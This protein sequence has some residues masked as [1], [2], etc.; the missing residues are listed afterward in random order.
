MAVIDNET[1]HA[2]DSLRLLSIDMIRVAGSGHPGI[3]LGAAPIIYTLYKHHM[4]INPEEP[5]W[6]NRDRF[7]MSAGHGSA[8][9]YATLFMSGYDLTL[10]DL[11][12]FRQ[13]DS[14]C[15]GHPE[16]GKTPGV[17]CTTGMLGQGLATAV[18]IALSERYL[19][20]LVAS[21]VKKQKLINYYTYVLAGDGDLM[22]GV[23]NEA[24]AIAGNQGL[25]KLIVLYDSNDVTLDGE[26]K[27]SNTE[28]I[29][30]RYDA[31]G[32][33]IDYVKDGNDP[34]EIDRAIARAKKINGKPSLIEIKTVIG[35]GSFNE[36]K[37]VVHG[38]PL[39]KDDIDHIRQKME[40]TTG[41]LEIEEIALKNIR[42]EIQDRIKNNY[43][44]W[45][46]Y[47]NSF[48]S[49]DNPDI[50]KI[51][52]FLEFGEIGCDFDSKNFQIQPSYNEELRESNS[53]I[54][55]VISSKT[56]FFLGGSADLSSSCKTNLYKEAE[57]TRQYVLG[58]NIYFGVREHAMGSILNGMALNNFQVY[59]S[60]F[61]VLADYLKPAIRLSAMMNLPVTYIFTH[62]TIG[63][64]QDG[65]TH[66]PIEHLTMLRTI[67][68]LDVIRPA[69]INEVIGAWD[70][71]L[72]HRRPT[73]LIIS[74][75]TQHILAGTNSSLVSK[76]A[77][78]VNKEKERLDAI[79]IATGTDLTTACLIKDEFKN[80]HPYDIRIVSMPSIEIFRREPIE[81][82]KEIIPDGVK[83]IVIEAGDITPWL[84]YTKEEYIIGLTT[85]GDSGKPEDVL[86]KMNFN[87]EQIKERVENILK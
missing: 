56:K 81:Y 84:R 10:D 18:G 80:T 53:K 32:W 73:S 6:I 78:I 14:K 4:N 44:P 17:D 30:K 75:E 70:Y 68:N 74:K 35:R 3:C 21:K 7:I 40:I 31:L 62:D 69:D 46:E 50:I 77:Y 61:L 15:P 64:G 22:E 8:L 79:I 76:G 87:Y 63:I 45:L 51:V 82:Q 48:K 33:H 11:Q 5:D 60:T 72:E 71:I 57:L 28:D 38:K 12:K 29:L 43:N 65:A 86:T 2:I 52:R 39:T 36:G 47:F 23:T 59:G 49:S 1:K 9:L 42:R 19:E 55:N 41:T 27:L 34:K 67:P 37:S 13:I 83:V 58:R 16:Y 54:M 26:L 85:Y 24:A 20:A 66:Q 25:G